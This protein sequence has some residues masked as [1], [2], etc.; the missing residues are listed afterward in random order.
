MNFFVSLTQN[1]FL[2]NWYD[3]RHEKNHTQDETPD[4]TANSGHYAIR[5]SVNQGHDEKEEGDYQRERGIN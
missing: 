4:H 1:S 3:N 2:D 5:I